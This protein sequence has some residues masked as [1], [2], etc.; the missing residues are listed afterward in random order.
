LPLSGHRRKSDWDAWNAR[1]LAEQPIVRLILDGTVV[2]VRLDRKATS[3]SLLVVLGIREDGQRC[4]SQSRACFEAHVYIYRTLL[5]YGATPWTV[6]VHY[7]SAETRRERWIVLGIG[8]GGLVLLTIAIGVAVFLARRLARPVLGLAEAA[9]RVEALDFA[10]AR[11]LP[12]GPVREVNQ[13]AEAVERMA[14]GLTWFETYLPKTLVRR[15]MAAG[16]ATPLT[17]TREVTVMFT[18]LER[19]SD[20]SSTH[21]AAEV[22]SYLTDLLARVGPIIEASG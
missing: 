15:L 10:G 5:D 4:R 3:I 16:T 8:I 6:G 1:L 18:D 22:V 17:D 2:R 19:Y 20:F 9:A 7:P 21:P 14:A 11:A 12:R 13:A